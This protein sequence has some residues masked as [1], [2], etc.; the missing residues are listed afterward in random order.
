MTHRFHHITVKFAPG[1][2]SGALTDALETAHPDAIV[3]YLYDPQGSTLVFQNA[4][5]AEQV[6]QY[7][8]DYAGSEFCDDAADRAVGRRQ[9]E[10][11]RR[12]I[13]RTG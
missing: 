7:C 10:A 8:E 1:E 6:A 3:E 9:V 13:E 5:V 11:I 2:V 12:A 4:R